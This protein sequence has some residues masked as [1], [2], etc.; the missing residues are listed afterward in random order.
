MERKRLEE[1][2]SIDTP[3]IIDAYVKKNDNGFTRFVFSK[4]RPE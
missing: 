1:G 2:F 3:S 4:R